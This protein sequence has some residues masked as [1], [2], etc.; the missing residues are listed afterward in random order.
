MCPPPRFSD[1]LAALNINCKIMKTLLMQNKT[2][3]KNE[4]KILQLYLNL[5]QLNEYEKAPCFL[6][7]NQN[8][9]PD[10]LLISGFLPV[11]TCFG[12]KIVLY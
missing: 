5:V 4:K 11:L 1:L 7:L 9:A 12:P 2:I 10:C 3:T 6:Q 8:L